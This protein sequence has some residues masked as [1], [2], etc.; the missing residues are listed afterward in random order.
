MAILSFQIFNSET[1]T[2][3]TPVSISVQLDSA[4]YSIGDYI[5]FT[6]TVSHP[7]T[8]HT[9]FSDVARRL[10]TQFEIIRQVAN[11][12]IEQ[13]T[14]LTEQKKYLITTFDTGWLRIPPM[15]AFYKT[16]SG[17]RDSALSD[18]LPVYVSGVNVDASQGPKPIKPI[19]AS[20]S[21]NPLMWYIGAAFIVLGAGSFYYWWILQRR[22][23]KSK[24]KK[25]IPVKPPYQ[26]T[27]EKL[28]ELDHEQLWQKGEL[29]KYYL[30]LTYILREYVEA[31]LKVPA[32]EITTIE[33]LKALKKKLTNTPLLDQLKRDLLL[34]DLV[35]FA[36]LKP[37]DADHQR[38]MDT[39]IE[40]VEK[41]KPELVLEKIET[42]G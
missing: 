12:S 25:V 18:P 30:R 38:V 15:V 10:G 5:G 2:A 6:V 29:D 23:R 28:E 24:R 16:S 35:K 36:K 37:E 33:M 11:D 20:E 32:L 22:K 21:N 27:K 39:I 4:G 42:T 3:Q 19:I 9:A 1:A 8:L 34:A 40:F 41:T 31:V 26:I 7:Y 13:E 17:K 14:F